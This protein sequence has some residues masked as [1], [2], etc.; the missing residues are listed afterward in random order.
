MSNFND[1]KDSDT[2]KN[3]YGSMNKLDSFN[4]TNVKINK[5]SS[6]KFILKNL[7]GIN[8]TFNL[9]SIIFEP[10]AHIAPQQKSEIQLAL[11]EEERRKKE[12]KAAAAQDAN[13]MGKKKEKGKKVDFAESAK[14]SMGGTNKEENRR[15]QPI[16]SDA[17][18]QTQKFTSAGGNTFTQ[19]KMVE[20]DQAFFLQKK[21][22]IAIVFSPN[23]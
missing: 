1:D 8:T 4:F 13:Q 11:E 3:I 5:I 12:E 10:P 22:G 15:T 7:S 21:K 20:K 9:N 18:E 19:T 14:K 16:L 23:E 17:H 2:W 6:N